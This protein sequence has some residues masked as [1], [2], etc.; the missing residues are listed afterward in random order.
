MTSQSLRHAGCK[1]GS[2][3]PLAVWEHRF[4]VQAVKNEKNEGQVASEQSLGSESTFL[5][6][7]PYFSLVNCGPGVAPLPS[8]CSPTPWGEGV[9]GSRVCMEIY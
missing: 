2:N 8:T 5:C 3:F 9:K 7:D 4:E 6:R 1:G